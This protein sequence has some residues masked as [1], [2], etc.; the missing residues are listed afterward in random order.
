[1]DCLFIVASDGGS[2]IEIDRCG[3]CGA[4][5]FD[6]GE[7]EMAANL[8]ARPS[9]AESEHPCP[10]CKQRMRSAALPRGLFAHHCDSC[11]G[12]FLDAATL[13]ALK[14][15]KL[16]RLPESKPRNELSV[17]FV[18]ARCNQK[19]PYAKGNATS[20]GLMCPTCVVNPQVEKIRRGP[21]S[22]HRSS[23]SA[24]SL[25]YDFDFIE[26]FDSIM[27]LFRR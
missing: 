4:L 12:T 15:D 25:G 24:G 5:W 7:L 17:G 18:C 11:Q 19:F 22:T 13:A 1:M 21:T 27:D 6:A 26:A 10:V 20:K 8:H 9:Q 3:E 23:L 16:P 2:E 14:T